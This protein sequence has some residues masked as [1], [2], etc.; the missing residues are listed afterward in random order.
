MLETLGLAEE[1]RAIEDAVLAAVQ[2][3]E[4]TRDVGGT[5]DTTAAGDSIAGRIYRSGPQ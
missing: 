2:A 3:R 4:I 5:L 1:S